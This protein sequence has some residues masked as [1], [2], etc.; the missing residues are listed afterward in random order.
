MD[1]TSA[2]NT[3]V[4]PSTNSN[5]RPKKKQQHSK[6]GQTSANAQHAPTKSSSASL[7][8]TADG[9]TIG[10]DLLSQPAP[11]SKN[12]THL[13]GRTLVPFFTSTGEENATLDL[14]HNAE[15]DFR[16][17]DD[18]RGQE[19]KVRA[20][21]DGYFVNQGSLAKQANSS[22]SHT[23]LQSESQSSQQQQK[24]REA[25]NK[26]AKSQAQQPQAQSRPPTHPQSQPAPANP[27][28]AK[29]K[30][31][32]GYAAAVAG[33]NAS[34]NNS[35]QLASVGAGSA[36]VRY[37]GAAFLASPSPL[38]VP[39]PK[40][41]TA[42]KTATPASPNSSRRVNV[43]HSAPP[44]ATSSVH[45]PTSNG[46]VHDLHASQSI[47]NLLRGNGSN[48]HSVPPSPKT[49]QRN[50]LTEKSSIPPSPSS[51]SASIAPYSHAIAAQPT[52][53]PSPQPVPQ[54]P[55]STYPATHMPT[56]H[57]HQA[58]PFGYPP[59]HVTHPPPHSYVPTS[60]PGQPSYYSHAASASPFTASVSSAPSSTV[61]LISAVHSRYDRPN[62]G[63]NYAQTY[64]AYQPH[65]TYG[66]YQTY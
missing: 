51:Q 48:G 6:K 63:A 21:V 4:D 66:A 47:M 52:L 65:A 57:M 13:V 29:S 49:L 37:A 46:F 40:F 23:Q 2:S 14:H 11:V 26:Q 15:L 16:V 25:K 31:K 53:L 50:A 28:P 7:R 41:L 10:A 17:D 12:L 27:S 33:A 5:G 62:I 24:K 58:S 3:G 36:P 35:A 38:Q 44:P 60:M 30:A 39:L 43:N 42:T 18:E 34:V 19:T 64:G 45:H 55:H 54:L 1:S 56:Q 8:A 32:K 20:F 59:H 9:V 61:P 22:L